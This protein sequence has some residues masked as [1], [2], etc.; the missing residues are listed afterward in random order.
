MAKGRKSNCPV[1]VRDWVISILNKTTSLYVRIYGLTGA[2]LAYSS[3]TEDGSADTDIYSEPFITK[4][5]GSISLEGKEVVVEATGARD[6]GQV[7]LDD[8]A[9][10]AG[11]DADVTLKMV[12]PYGNAFVADYIV[13]GNDVSVD[14]TGTTLSWDLDMVGEAEPLPYVQVTSIALNDGASPVANPLALET[15][16]AAKVITVVFTPTDSSNQ[17]FKITNSNRKVIAVSNVTETGFS[18]TPM[19]VG[20]STITVTSI[21]GTKT[22]SVVINVTLPA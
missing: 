14:D 13:S 7:M 9:V 12:D 20:T 2:S 21:N 8:A 17:R 6:E 18:I 22:A 5:S 1:N 11:C 16:D 4:R 10:L 19:S 15:E 3:N